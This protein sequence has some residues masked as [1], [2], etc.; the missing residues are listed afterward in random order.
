MLRK[1]HILLFYGEMSYTY[2]LNPFGSLP[3]FSFTMSLFSFCFSDLSIGESV[4]L[5]STTIIVC[6][7]MC[8]LNVF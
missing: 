8:V 4:V 6:G 3:L 5:K 7:S 1:R 2:L